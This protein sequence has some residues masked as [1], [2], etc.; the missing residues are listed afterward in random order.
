MLATI[1]EGIEEAASEN[2]L[3]TFVTNSLDDQANQAAR[4]EM[5]FQRRVEG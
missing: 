1:Y 3:S 2:G 4:T 5:M